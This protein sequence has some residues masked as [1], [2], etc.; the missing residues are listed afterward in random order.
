M[1]KTRDGLA[2]S[3]GKKEGKGREG[4]RSRMPAWEKQN[5]VTELWISVNF[6]GSKKHFFFS[7]IQKNL[8]HHYFLIHQDNGTKRLVAL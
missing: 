3:A 6:L 8:T 5:S 4:K 7:K 1:G 2:S